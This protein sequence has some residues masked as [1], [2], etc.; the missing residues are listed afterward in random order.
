MAFRSEGDARVWERERVSG[1]GRPGAVVPVDVLGRLSRHWY[2]GRLSDAWR[3]ASA[4][5]KQAMLREAVL[6]GP[7]WELE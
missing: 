1:G 6:T 2:G 4:A 3:P 5:A 7:F